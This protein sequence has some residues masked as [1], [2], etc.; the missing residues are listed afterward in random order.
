MARI[1]QNL[2]PGVAGQG[3]PAAVRETIR[4]CVASDEVW[5]DMRRLVT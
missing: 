3:Q 5:Q 4:I 1:T 2:P